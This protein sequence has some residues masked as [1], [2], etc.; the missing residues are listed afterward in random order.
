MLISDMMSNEQSKCQFSVF[1]ILDMILH[2]NLIT[3]R[4]NTDEKDDARDEI[5]PQEMANF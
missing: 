2:W 4:Y 3:E 1:S 5:M